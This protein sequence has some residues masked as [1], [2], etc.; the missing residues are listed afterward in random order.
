MSVLMQLPSLLAKNIF[1]KNLE[2]WAWNQDTVPR[3]KVLTA[4][5]KDYLDL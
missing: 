2:I 4:I 5:R 3:G 1:M